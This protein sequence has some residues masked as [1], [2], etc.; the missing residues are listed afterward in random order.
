MSLEE[1]TFAIIRRT[2]SQVRP[3]LGFDEQDALARKLFETGAFVAL[4]PRTPEDLT[5]NLARIRAACG[6]DQRCVDRIALDL[7]QRPNEDEDSYAAR[8]FQA[9]GAGSMADALRSS[10]EVW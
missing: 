10:E 6:I 3:K 5:V 9:S 1:T 2:V 4:D 8:R 7:P